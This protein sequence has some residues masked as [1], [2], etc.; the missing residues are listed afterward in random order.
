[1][2]SYLTEFT[3]SIAV[4][5]LAAVSLI[6]VHVGVVWLISTYCR[7]DR[8]FWSLKKERAARIAGVIV[9][10]AVLV[11]P[12]MASWIVYLVEWERSSKSAGCRSSGARGSAWSGFLPGG[13]ERHSAVIDD[14]PKGDSPERTL[15]AV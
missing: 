4:V 12:S 5:S 10:V 7:R 8:V 3:G 2:L 15:Q 13:S 14:A 9:A 11:I 1:M 6:V